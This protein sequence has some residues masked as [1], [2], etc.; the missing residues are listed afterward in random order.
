MIILI[1]AYEPDERLVR[2]AASIRAASDAHV[3]VVD[4]GSGSD[5]RQV[6]DAA[7]ALGCTVIGHATN[8]GKGH[9]LKE[10]FRYVALHHPGED[11]VCADCDGQ[12]TVVDIVR[13]ADRLRSAHGAMV[14]GERRFTGVV[15]AR[16][17]LGNAAT[18]VLVRMATHLPVH[19]TQTGL[20]GYPASMLDWLQTVDGDRFEYELNLLLHATGAGYEVEE[21]GIETIYLDGNLS[22]HFRPVVD[23]VRVC[24]PLLR[25]SLSSLAAFGLDT[26]AL[27]ALHTLTGNL[28]ASVVGA[29]VI[30]STVNFLTNRRLVFAHGQDKRIGAAA[31]QYWTLAVALLA[32]SYGLLSAL[33]HAGLPLLAAK[34]LTEATLFAVSYQVQRRLVFARPSE[35]RPPAD[36]A[37]MPTTETIGVP[38]TRARAAG[39]Q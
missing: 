7:R 5:Y 31:I 1:P 4:D 16:S 10:G 32:A 15:P 35:V 24:A 3:V 22:S 29:R 25:F 34:V 12:H 13:V 33:T 37:P 21:I 36:G 17:R 26:V 39:A 27:L 38:D 8:R 6:F 2:L 11:V 9:A 28:L 19:D 18:G 14:L 23:S 20:R 30:S